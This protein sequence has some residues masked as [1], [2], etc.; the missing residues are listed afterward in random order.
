MHVRSGEEPI[1]S[2]IA[3]RRERERDDIIHT[4]TRTDDSRVM[5]L[6]ESSN[7]FDLGWLSPSILRARESHAQ[8]YA[9]DST[10][11]DYDRL[12]SL[13]GRA[14]VENHR[15]PFMISM[16]AINGREKKLINWVV[17]VVERSIFGGV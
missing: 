7:N 9:A 3:L 17:M 15:Q 2:I 8:R 10:L 16:M 6:T 12:S 11:S 14:D 1:L 5:T 13:H 4:H